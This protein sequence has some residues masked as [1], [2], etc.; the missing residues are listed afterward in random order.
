MRNPAEMLATE[1]FKTSPLKWC[2]I[3]LERRHV[4]LFLPRLLPTKL[5]LQGAAKSG[6]TVVHIDHHTD[7][8]RSEKPENVARAVELLSG[9]MAVTDRVYAYDQLKGVFHF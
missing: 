6:K 1:Y 8:S 3:F 2:C 5:V 9:A 4:A 7:P